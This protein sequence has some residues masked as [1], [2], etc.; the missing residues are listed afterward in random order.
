MRNQLIFIMIAI[1]IFN[2]SFQCNKCVDI[3]D[4][5]ID[6]SRQWLPLKG[7]TQLIFINS[8][9]LAKM[10]K[11]LVVDT[12]ETQ[13]SCTGKPYKYESIF[14]RLSLDTLG[15][16]F[17]AFAIHPP[18]NLCIQCITDRSNEVNGCNILTKSVFN[19]TATNLTNFR[20]RSSVYSEVILLK[21][22]L[23]NP[24]M[25]SVVI[26]KNFGIV[27]FRYNGDSFILQ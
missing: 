9:R 2:T 1:L 7:K 13:T 3:P 14:G 16:D 22:S 19:G 6:N 5:L 12:I 11:L 10:F 23:A 27:G 25:D 21:S 20:L 15:K 24:I 17:I 4:T 8:N 18:N 26:A